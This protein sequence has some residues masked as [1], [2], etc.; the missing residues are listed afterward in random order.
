MTERFISKF[1]EGEECW[2]G[3][4]AEHKVEEVVFEDDPLPHRHPYTS[5]VCHRHFQWIMG[6]AVI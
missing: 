6:P 1:C 2:C 5:Y 4:P 3:A